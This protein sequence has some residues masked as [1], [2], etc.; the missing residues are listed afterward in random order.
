MNVLMIGDIFGKPGRRAIREL[1]PDLRKEKQ[2]DL[3]IANGENAAGGKGLTPETAEELFQDGVDIITLG[4]HYL[5]QDSIITDLENNSNIIRPYNYIKAPGKGFVM[6]EV[7]GNKVAVIN[8]AGRV[9]MFEADSPFEGVQKILEEVQQQTP[10]IFVDFHAEATSE[11]RAMGFFLNGKV[12]A[13]IGTHT[14]VQTADEQIL[15]EGTA[16]LTDAGMTGPHDSVIG[17]EKEVAIARF[18][19]QERGKFQVAEGDIRLNAAFISV[20]HETGRA[21]K[22]ERINLKLS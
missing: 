12:S 7:N 17:L 2:I 3:V 4:N 15:S 16:Y 21:K 18:A 20:D 13:V 19:R 22:I 11:K 5:D 10:L 14:H 9:H 8:L 1:L 6:L